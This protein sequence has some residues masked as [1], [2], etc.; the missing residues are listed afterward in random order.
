M[1]KGKIELSRPQTKINR[2]RKALNLNMAG[3][4]A[5]KSQMIGVLTG[6]YI[7]N[8]PSL[9][10]FIAA[11]TYLQLT[12]S[13]LVKVFEIWRDVFM[14]TE[15]DAKRN[16][17]GHFVVDKRPPAHFKRFDTFK[18][19]NNII[20]FVNGHIIY[21]GS[22]DNFKAHDGKEFAYA[23][24]DETKDT[25]EEAVT[26][27]ILARLS[28]RGLFV[29]DGTEVITWEQTHLPKSH[30][31][32]FRVV[33]PQN[34]VY[35]PDYATR[36][37]QIDEWN[38]RAFN[39]SWIHTSPAIGQVE[40][41]VEM[42]DLDKF[43][44][45]IRKEI[46]GTDERGR[47]AF[48]H[49]EYDNKCIVIFSTYHNEENLPANYIEGRKAVLSENEVLK[50]VYGYPFSKTGGEYYPYFERL[51]HVTKVPYLHSL[52]V[53]V[54][55]DFN[56]LPYMTMICAQIQTVDRYV[57]EL[58]RK[59]LEFKE[60][61]KYLEVLQ[62]RVFK[63]YCLESPENTV[64]KVAQAFHEDFKDKPN[65]GVS[66]YGDAS[67]R[68]RIPGLG[69]LTNYKQVEMYMSRY[70]HSS[71]NRVRPANIGVFARRDLINKILEG[72]FP[73]VELYIDESCVNTIRDMEY[74][75]LGNDGK[76]KERERDPQ[77]GSTYEKLGHTSD[78]L[79]YMLC[80]MLKQFITEE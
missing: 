11:N 19:Y 5:G 27:V 25:K 50:L 37:E 52:P 18:D 33:K 55:W 23:H 56:V 3:Q 72:K 59:Y 29:Y 42:F 66:Y 38:M 6:P 21:I 77:T 75:K 78:A 13:T 80:E 49:K 31:Q 17:D 60:G 48:F 12:Q 20:S 68:N 7:L 9:K 47:P 4:R 8:Y 36:T 32:R 46:Q 22:L 73:N 24:L 57:D 44:P 2:S 30:S 64:E 79:E 74:L 35:I 63:E 51:K 45:E 69:S 67:G 15:Y 65:N 1:Q 41:L 16:P 28:Q 71:S 58:G 61:R 62:V 34:L 43:E 26:S 39:P 40:W 53:H 14:L 10:G 70:L 54:S 76:L